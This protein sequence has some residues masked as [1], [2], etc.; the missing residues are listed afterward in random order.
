MEEKPYAFFIGQVKEYLSL[1]ILYA[2]FISILTLATPISVQS[3]V[4]TVAFGPYLQP[5]VILSLI[6]FS[7][8]VLLCIFKSL[9]YLLVEYMQRK[10][11]AKISSTM[12]YSYVEKENDYS[13]TKTMANRFFEIMLIQKSAAY[14]VTELIAITLQTSLGLILIS[15]YHPFFIF[16]SLL[17][18]FLASIFIVVLGRRAVKTAVNESSSKHNLAE[19]IESL[20]ENDHP[21]SKSSR[22]KKGDDHIEDYLNKRRKHFFHLFTQNI[23]FMALFAILNSLLLGL[24]GYLVVSSQLSLGQLVAAE[25]ILNAILYHFLYAYK[26]LESFYDLYAS[27][28]KVKIFYPTLFQKGYSF[29][30]RGTSYMKHFPSVAGIYQPLR[31]NKL[32]L[33]TFVGIA[34]FMICLMFVPWQQSSF[35]NGQ[36]IAKNPNDRVQFITAPVNGIVEEWLVVDGE[37]VEKGQ[38]IVRVIDNDPNYFQRLELQ[39]DAARKRYLSAK[40]A[41]DTAKLNYERQKQ[42]MAEGLSS[43]KEFEQAKIKYKKLIAEEAAVSVV[44]TKA[45]TDVS[46]QSLQ[47]I[48][49]PREGKILRILLGSG[50]TNVS[51]GSNLVEFVPQTD[52]LAVEIFV[53]GNDLPLVYEGRKVRLQFEGWPAVQFSGWPSVAIGSFG[54]VVFNVDPWV[55]KDGYFRVI[56]VP[57]KTPGQNE[58]PD[59]IFLRQGSRVMGLVLLDVVSLGYEFWRLANGFPKSLKEKPSEAYLK[60]KKIKAL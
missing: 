54:G 21:D 14:L 8:L 44:L 48:V 57:D 22:I 25:I 35:G 10:L 53:D 38:P 58:W 41:S 33:K 5:I 12:I 32:V 43:R 23:L 31:S 52:E 56:V 39:K 29:D 50:T 51:K 55:S 59:E 30:R 46:R 4:N 24:G 2:V 47:E 3:L 20:T 15:F 9:Q 7:L 27:S 49:A 37:H 45:E 40:E 34:I 17:T 16:F 42:L 11:I 6:L 13:R 60:V 18:L 1:I 26:Y 36:V 19:Y 28:D